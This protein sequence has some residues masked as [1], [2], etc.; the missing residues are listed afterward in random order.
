[1]PLCCMSCNDNINT[2]H[3]EKTKIVFSIDEFS[4]VSQSRTIVHPDKDYTV[5]WAK[6]DIIGIFPEEG[7]QEPFAIPD[8]QANQGSATFDGGYWALKDG[9]RY[10]AYYPFDKVN[11]ESSNM[12]KTIPVNYEGQKQT[13]TACCVGSH[14]F[15]YSDWATAG[16]GSVY[17]QFHHIGSL[18]VITLPIPATTTYSSLTIETENAII[19]IKGTYDLTAKLTKNQEPSFVA[20]A[21]SLSKS[22]TVELADFTGTV[23]T[24]A[25]IYMMLPPVDL[26]EKTLTLTLKATNGGSCVYSVKGKNVLKGKKTEFTGK[27]TNST[28]TGTTYEWLIEQGIL[29]E[30]YAFDV[31]LTGSTRLQNAKDGGVSLSQFASIIKSLKV[32]GNLNSTD[33]GFIRKLSALEAL[34]LSDANIIEGGDSYYT[35][36]SNTQCTTTANVFPSYFMTGSNLTSLK[37]IALPNSVT[38]I[39]GEAFSDTFD[40]DNIFPK[41]I[42]ALDCI[43]LG[44]KLETIWSVA[45]ACSIRTIHLPKNVKTVGTAAFGYC[46]YL[47][48]I[49]VADDN[50]V[51]KSIDGVLYEKGNQVWIS[52][53]GYV[54]GYTLNV[55]PP[56]KQSFEFP[57]DLY[58][59]TIGSRSFSDCTY[60]TE[61]NFSDGVSTISTSV[62]ARCTALKKVTFPASVTQVANNSN[63]SSYNFWW[64]NNAMEE[65]HLKHTTPPSWYFE[66]GSETYQLPTTCKLYVPYN[67]NWS[68]S[69]STTRTNWSKNFSIQYVYE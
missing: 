33:I 56:A 50:T 30:N 27:P 31:T 53:T 19:P 66:T 6:G 34:D 16:E 42:Y 47:E 52:G 69:S 51:F 57:E 18:V 37:F 24:N 28:V 46:P 60:L 63:G 38:K 1:M 43:V 32:T 35:N 64:G 62:F 7:Y 41:S 59:T 55:C 4:D 14:A 17:F 61:I 23:N 2:S 44:E 26:S 39:G 13:G 12:K 36:E 20:D 25:T 45:F 10:N 54:D 11:F 29:D 67:T 9:L 21:S 58:I 8:N 49:T 5:T 65:L 3:I 40:D 15:T 68:N 48:S 22:I